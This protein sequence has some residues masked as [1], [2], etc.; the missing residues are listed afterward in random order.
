[1]REDVRNCVKAIRKITDFKPLV[2]ITLGSGLGNYAQKIRTVCEI[3]YDAIP[4]FP[5]STVSGHDGRFIMG[6]VKK[7]PVICMKGRVHFYEGYSMDQ[8][9][10]PLRVMQGLGAKILF[11]TNAAGGLNETFRV[12]DLSMI[13]DHISVFTVNPLIGPNDDKEGPRFHDMTQ[14]YDLKLQKLLEETAKRLKI[15]LKRG[16]YVQLTGPSFE[17]PAEIRMLRLLGAD[18][19]GMSTAVEAIV[20][21]HMGMRVCGVS[22]ITNMAAGISKELLSHEDVKRAGEEAEPRFVR[23]VTESVAAMGAPAAKRAAGKTAAGRKTKAAKS[24]Q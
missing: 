23:L 16:V 20:A 7:T 10:M 18:M 2:A 6:Y 11:L 9:V 1:M 13:T 15:D 22:L 14:A 17:T 21:R 12:G 19:V 24:K 5:V 8:V 3:P 4:G